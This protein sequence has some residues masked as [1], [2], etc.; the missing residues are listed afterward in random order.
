MAV[1]SAC[2]QVPTLLQIPSSRKQL[3]QT[4]RYNRSSRPE[5]HDRATLLHKCFSQRQ[6]QSNSTQKEKEEF[7]FER[8]FSNLNQATLKRE[9]GFPIAIILFY[10]LDKDPLT[11]LIFLCSCYAFQFHLIFLSFF[12]L[13]LLLSGSLSSAIFL[14]AG[15]TVCVFL[16]RYLHFV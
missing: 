4:H 11:M 13:F 8:L 1:S 15:T 7:E 16:V 6:S 2:F 10:F 3:L 5:R 12:F 9:P 14:V